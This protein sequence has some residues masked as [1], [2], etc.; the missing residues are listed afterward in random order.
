MKTPP[1]PRY[2]CSKCDSRQCYVLETKPSRH[3]RR[4]R[5]VCPDCGYRETTYELSQARLDE[6]IQADRLYQAI[7]QLLPS[8]RGS[9]DPCKSEAALH[10]CVHCIHWSTDRCALDIPEAGGAYASECSVFVLDARST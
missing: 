3:G 4:R 10:D 8:T 1:P 9:G 6:L 5:Y 7:R 2:R